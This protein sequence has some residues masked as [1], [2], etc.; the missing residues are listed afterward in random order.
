MLIQGQD[1]QPIPSPSL[2]KPWGSEPVTENL[3]CG[4]S[5]QLRSD[6]GGAIQKSGYDGSQLVLTELTE[7]SVVVGGVVL[8]GILAVVV[9]VTAGMLESDFLPNRSFQNEACET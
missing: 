8:G 6:G 9:L 2:S 3:F 4:I 5:G 7:L 1:S